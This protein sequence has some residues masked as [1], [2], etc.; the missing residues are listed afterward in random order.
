M[1]IKPNI[2]IVGTGNTAW[3]LAPALDNAGFAVKAV[4]GRNV[5]RTTSLVQR[6]YMAEGKSDLDFSE[7]PV[8]LV[9]IAVS[10]DAI[11]EVVTEM[12]LPEGAVL[13]HTSG[14]QPLDVLAL[15]ATED[16][17]VFYPLQ[18]FSRDRTVD[19]KDV[20]I[21]IETTTNKAENTLEMVA[22]GIAK[23]VYKI[24]SEARKAIHLA[25]VFACNFTNHM[26]TLSKDIIIDHGQSFDMLKPLITETIRKSLTLGPENGQTGPAMRRDTQTIESHLNLLSNDEEKAKIYKLITQHIMDH[27]DL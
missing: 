4:Y 20:P 21:C 25:A 13:A 6:L 19:F 18:T 27:Y 17:G 12:V 9:I 26:L 10:D 3:N 8:Q 2:A 24:D 14:A 11:R 23:K 22:S 7:D 15:A 5:D 16:I 1:S